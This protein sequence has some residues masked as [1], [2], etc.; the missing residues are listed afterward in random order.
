MKNIFLLFLIVFPG[1][2]IGQNPM[3]QVLI[4]SRKKPLPADSVT[5]IVTFST[6]P[7]YASSEFATIKYNKQGIFNL[8]VDDNK[9]ECLQIESI[10]K[11]F[12]YKDGTGA[13]RK[14]TAA[15]AVNG[16]NFSGTEIGSNNGTGM[17]YSDY[18][19]LISGG[20]D[21][22]NHSNRHVDLINGNGINIIGYKE[23]LLTLNELYFQNINYTMNS[24][25]V[26]T[27]YTNFVPF[28]DELGFLVSSSSGSNSY[29][30]AFPPFQQFGI[31][32]NI[33]PSDS[34]LLQLK[35]GFLHSWTDQNHI[36]GFI[37]H[38]KNMTNS[39]SP[40]DHRFYRIGTHADNFDSTAFRKF[41]D[42]LSTI[43]DDKIWFTTARE[44]MEYRQTAN[45][46]VK[47][48]SIIANTLIIS[49]NYDG[50]RDDFRWR[51]LSLNINSDAIITNV[52]FVGKADELSFNAAT[53]LINVYKQNLVFSSYLLK[54]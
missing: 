11:D 21:V 54:P 2:M 23:D 1:F 18:S 14:F 9:S 53:G 45:Q 33:S 49:I 42:T 19:I 34:G 25:V 3:I 41:I 40:L 17:A 26:P 12:T 22:M 24:F 52:S 5:I 20:W 30:P 50:L 15:T 32:S 27:N 31:V 6:P 36:N 16:F 44:W 7:T 8:E 4:A 13:D 43:A 37:G 28:A 10:L 29:K 46:V 39:S 35:R 47:H 48:D 38:F 51:D